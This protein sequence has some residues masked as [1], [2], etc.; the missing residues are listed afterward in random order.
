[1]LRALRE[2]RSIG[3]VLPERPPR[4]LIEQIIAAGAQA[5]NH[6]H[7]E[8]WRF[9]VLTGAARDA[10][11]DVMATSARMR[12]ENSDGPEARAIIERER[13][14]PLRAPVVVAVAAVPNDGPKVV[15]V[16]EFAAVVAAVQNMLL[17]AHALGL[18]AM[19][20]TGK[21]AYDP[22]VKA[23]LGLAES[24]DIVAFVYIGYSNM[25]PSPDRRRSPARFTTWLGWEE[26]DSVS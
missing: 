24:D 21:P 10:L 18:G 19:W 13:N 22:A 15:R 1:M 8:P 9:T 2:R 17:A 26:S 7:T 6:H 14:K 11:G 20:R 3:R 5:P 23:F 12:L 16:E 4:A 25:Q